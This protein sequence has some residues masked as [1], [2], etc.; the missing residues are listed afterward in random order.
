MALR[1]AHPERVPGRDHRRPGRVAS[2]EGVHD[3]R[4]ARRVGV[5]GMGAEPGPRRAVGPELLAAGQDV[6]ALD[7]LG[8]TRRQQHRDVVAG[9]GVAGGDHFAVERGLED[10]ALRLVPGPIE[11]GGGAHPVGVHRHR[12]GGGRCV[13]RQ[14]SLTG[15]HLRQVEAPAAEVRGHG[16]GQVA[17]GTQVGEVLVEVL[18][19]PIELAG[20]GAEPLERVVGQLAVRPGLGVG[21]DGHAHDADDHDGVSHAPLAGSH[22]RRG[23]WDRRERGARSDSSA[24]PANASLPSPAQARWRDRRQT[25]QAWRGRRA[26]QRRRSQRG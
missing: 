8:D 9:F 24:R 22:G 5:D 14:A 13:A 18:V 2:D 20:A 10:P 15:R 17:R 23:A 11:L 12:Q 19:G 3:L 1:R 25:P 7:P 6:T 21:C 26:E 4:A 16:G